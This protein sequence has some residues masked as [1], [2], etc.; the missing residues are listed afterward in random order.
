ML[1]AN[2]SLSKES[3]HVLLE[4]GLVQREDGGFAA[5]LRTK[6]WCLLPPHECLFSPAGFVFSRDLRVNFVSRLSPPQPPHL[7]LSLRVS[8]QQASKFRFSVCVISEKYCA[9]QLGAEPGDAI[10]G[11]GIGSRCPVRNW[12]LLSGGVYATL[13]HPCHNWQIHGKCPVCKNCETL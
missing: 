8:C 6:L 1:A 11:S 2:P 4:R 9:L 7:P 3:V 10:E 13:L 5:S 12:L